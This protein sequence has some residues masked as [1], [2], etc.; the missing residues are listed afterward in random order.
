MLV[1]QD[2]VNGGDAYSPLSIYVFSNLGLR[3]KDDHYRYFS[4]SDA[5]GRAHYMEELGQLVEHL[6]NT[7]SLAMWVPFNEGWGQ[8]DALKAVQAIRRRDATRTIDHASGWYDQGGGD[9]KSIHW[10]FR[11]YRHRQPPGEQR[12]VCLTEYGGYNCAVPGH[13]RGEKHEFGYK[14]IAD[15]AAFNRAFRRLM[16]EQIIP[17]KAGGLAA[18]VYTQLSDVEGELN[19]L[20]TYDRKVCKADEA[21]FRSV[22]RRLG[23][24]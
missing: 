16:E 11:P 3:V 22:N 1:W 4:R 9:I 7:V 21:L 23:E 10:Y 12:P 5:K 20:L 18:A 2:M 15:P 17:A 14:K 8:F 6:Y 13:C 19:G 24:D